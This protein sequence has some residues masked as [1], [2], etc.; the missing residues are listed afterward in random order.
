MLV[1]TLSR[2]VG[3]LLQ[4]CKALAKKA[5]VMIIR[6]TR[7]TRPQHPTLIPSSHSKP[8]IENEGFRKLTSRHGREVEQL[9]YF[10]HSNIRAP[11]SPLF[12]CVAL[13]RSLP[14][15]SFSFVM[16][17]TVQIPED[18]SLTTS[19]A[20]APITSKG[21]VARQLLDGIDA[22]FHHE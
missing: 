3:C 5:S 14:P 21:Y 4:R 10:L 22:L 2:R 13:T 9:R 18:Y 7:T 1:C 12:I 17:R 16:S 6:T 20:V 19:R 8:N 11:L 15:R